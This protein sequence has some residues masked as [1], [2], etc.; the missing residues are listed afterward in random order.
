MAF[1]TKA[2]LLRPPFKCHG[3]KSYLKHYVLS[4]FPEGY[5]SLRYVEPFGGAASV[6]LNK[7]P[8]REEH[9]NDLHPGIA[10]IFDSIK[11]DPEEFS[12]R[13]RD[14]TYSSQTFSA[15]LQLATTSS[16]SGI[17]LAVAEYALRRMSRGGLKKDFDWSER[18]RGGKPECVNAWETALA[19]IPALSER[20]RD[21]RIT[22]QDGLRLVEEMNDGDVLAYLDPPYLHATRSAKN[23]YDYE[24]AEADHARLCEA[25]VEF[26]GKALISGYDSALYNKVLAGWNRVERK[27]ANHSSQAKLKEIKTE[28]LWRNY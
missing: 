8:G 13:L 14:L 19:Q 4:N 15:T 6:L 2:R 12:K 16:L 26:K 28:V 18:L 9:L 10:A 7:S 20:L 25:L 11:G 24:M 1:K 17:D 22:S 21:V 27:I 23:A 3:G 5:Q